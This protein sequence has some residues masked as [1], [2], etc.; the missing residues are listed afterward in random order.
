MVNNIKDWS[1]RPE[2]RQILLEFTSPKTPRQVERHLHIKKLKMQPF[3]D[4]GII[5][6]LNPIARK[7]RLYQLTNK[8]RKSLNLQINDESAKDWDLIGW[9]L[10]SP[11]QRYVILQ[12]IAIDTVKRTSEHIR[13]RASRL[14]HHLTRI[15]TKE[16]LRELIGK[17]LVE[18]ELS[19]TRRR[20]YWISEKGIN[21]Q[22][23][24]EQHI[25]KYK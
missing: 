3:I 10:A 5:K 4:K 6:S 16:I 2:I 13:K 24:I 23:N 1:K 12:T 7:G 15:S 14:N 22:K 25:E 19:K 21:I 11:R 9:I 20:F 17:Y 8:G 18:T